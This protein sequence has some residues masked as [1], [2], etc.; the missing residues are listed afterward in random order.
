MGSNRAMLLLSVVLA[1]CS[2]TPPSVDA[3]AGKKVYTE[4][5]NT[6]YAMISELNFLCKN[7]QFRRLLVIFQALFLT[8]CLRVQ[9]GST[10]SSRRARGS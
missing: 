7:K 5:E 9:T 6:K 3:N 10:T 1:L 4:E 8:V 2:V